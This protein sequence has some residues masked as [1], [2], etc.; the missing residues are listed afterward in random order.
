MVV[1][2]GQIKLLPVNINSTLDKVL[3]MVPDFLNKL[4]DAFKK[5]V[6]VKKEVK[7]EGNG[8]KILKES[9]LEQ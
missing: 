6:I 4:E 9:G 8:E 2:N 1:G 3:D 5:K 7:T